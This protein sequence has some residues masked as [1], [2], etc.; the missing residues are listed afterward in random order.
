MADEGSDAGSM[1]GGQ[2]RLESYLFSCELSSEVPFYTFQADEDEDL[3][4]FLELRTVCVGEG[5]KDEFNVVEVTAFNYQGKKTSVPIANLHISR[6]PML[7]LGGFELMAPVTL[8]LKSGTGPVT[9]SGMHLVA[10][11]DGEESDITD[12]DDELEDEL[13]PIKPAKKKQKL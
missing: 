6:L 10:S 9:V 5:A 11:E 3:E 12:D 8:R 2:S 1:P 7:S 13:E 4:H